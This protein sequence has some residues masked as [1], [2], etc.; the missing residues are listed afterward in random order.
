MK[1]IFIDSL[2]VK[3]DIKLIEKTLSLLKKLKL[4]KNISVVKTKINTLEN[5]CISSFSGNLKHK[6]KRFFSIKALKYKNKSDSG[7]QPIIDQKE[8][9]ILGIICQKHNGNLKFLLQAKFEPGNKN[10]YQIS[11]TIQATKSNIERVH[12]GKSQK[13]YKFFLDK[14]SKIHFSILLSEQGTKFYNKKNRN[15]LIEVPE[16]KSILIDKDFIWL[17]LSEIKVLISKNNIINMSTRSVLSCINLDPIFSCNIPLLDSLILTKKD[18]ENIT[19]LKKK[20]Y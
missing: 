2:L 19:L 9:G 13:Y 10:I 7:I 20:I 3:P 1:N 14:K 4:N 15:I 11:P 5:W 8:I 18:K 16:N 17:T 6:S 12:G